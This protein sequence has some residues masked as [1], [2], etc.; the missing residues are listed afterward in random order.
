[1]KKTKNDIIQIPVKARSHQITIM[2][3]LKLFKNLYLAILI[4]FKIL[5]HKKFNLITRN[6]NK[7]SNLST[8]FIKNNRIKLS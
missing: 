4:L 6:F 3:D 2:K 5:V 1:M 7:N 8:K